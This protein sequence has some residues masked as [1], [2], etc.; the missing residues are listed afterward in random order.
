MQLSRARGSEGAERIGSRGVMTKLRILLIGTASAL[1]MAAPQGAFAAAAEA[2]AVDTADI[3]PADDA[4]TSG[5]LEEIIVT[6]TRRSENQQDVPVALLTL[7]EERLKDLRINTFDDYIRALPGVAGSG[8]GPGKK[9]IFIRGVAAGRTPVR[10]STVGPEPSVGLYLDEIPISTAGRNIDIFAVDFNRVEALKG[11]QGTLFGASSESGNVRLI[12]NKPELDSYSGSGDFGI[13]NTQSGRLSNLEQG[14][15]NIPLIKDKFA[16]RIVGYNSTEGGFIDNTFGTRQLPLTNPGL[17]GVVPVSRETIANGD[18]ARNDQ[19]EV[20]YRGVRA[21]ALYKI[22]ENWDFY[23]QHLTQS[24]DADGV[25]EYEPNFTSGKDL[26]AR[27]FSPAFGRD[28]VNLTSWTLKGHEGLLDLIYNGSY[29]NR[30]F[31]GQTDYTGYV[32]VGSSVPYYIC[33]PGFQECGSPQFFTQ[34]FFNTK[35]LTQEFRVAS[36]ASKRVRGILGLFY[37]GQRT[38]ERSNFNYPGTIFAGFAPNAPI[39][40]IFA[41][42]PEPREPGVAFFNDFQRTRFEKSVFGEIS[43]D[44][45]KSLTATFGFRHYSIDLALRGQSSF[46]TQGP[47]DG[48]AGRPLAG[49]TVNQHG[50]IYRAN[51]SWKPVDQALFYFTYSEGFRAGNFNRNG[52]GVGPTNIPF[53]YNPDEVIN[54]EVGFKTQFL[55]DRIRLNGSVYHDAFKNIQQSILDFSISNVTFF[56]NVG[57]ARINGGELDAE[58]AVTKNLRLFGGLSVINSALTELPATLVRTAPVGSPLAHAPKFSGDIGA[59]YTWKIGSYDAFT[60]V[61]AT[62][63]G[64]RFST[65]VTTDRFELPSYTQVDLT[66]GVS[67]DRWSASVYVNNVNNSVGQLDATQTDNTYRVVPTRPRTVGFRASYA[68]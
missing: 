28:R 14:V 32:D 56:E 25:F 58:A 46:A 33:R 23:A 11:P 22:D 35:R 20:T 51:L 7:S 42:D 45:L 43:V 1:A 63:T 54:Y 44:L 59:R 65:I 34:E 3:A 17:G 5:G 68:F 39:P 24:I 66:A 2:V 15:V 57:R 48:N 60:Q 67:R 37:D 50:N 12:P 13:S 41:S 18:I 52:N 47:V 9:E 31:E 27:T 10:I 62:Y 6:A 29:T 21:S 8:Q 36:D 38:I 26:N 64:D 16:V 30:R 55:Q 61:F 53:F 49:R 19:N 40:N 4:A